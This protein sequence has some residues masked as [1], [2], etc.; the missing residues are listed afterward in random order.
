MNTFLQFPS[1]KEEP[2]HEIYIDRQI[3]DPIRELQRR[4]NT[5]DF[6]R[7]RPGEEINLEFPPFCSCSWPDWSFEDLFDHEKDMH[8]N[9]N[10]KEKESENNTKKKNKNKTKTKSKTQP[11]AIMKE[12]DWDWAWEKS[13]GEKSLFAPISDQVF[14]KGCRNLWDLMPS[15][16]RATCVHA[17]RQLWLRIENK[18]GL[19]VFDYDDC[20][21]FTT[22]CACGGSRSTTTFPIPPSMHLLERVRDR[23]GF[24]KGSRLQ[25]VCVTSRP[26]KY[27][28][29]MLKDAY[30]FHQRGA[31]HPLP[32][33]ICMHPYDSV[34]DVE[35]REQNDV[36]F[37]LFT[38]IALQRLLERPVVGSIGDS[39]HDVYGASETS[40]LLPNLHNW[41]WGIVPTWKGR[42]HT[43]TLESS[44]ELED[45]DHRLTG[46]HSLQVPMFA[47]PK[48]EARKFHSLSPSSHDLKVLSVAYT[49]DSDAT[50]LEVGKWCMDLDITSSPWSAD[51]LPTAFVNNIMELEKQCRV[52]KTLFLYS[53]N[54]KRTFASPC[55]LSPNNSRSDSM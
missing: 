55:A 19:V 45:W 52:K 36:P 17:C 8:P 5:Q 13:Q 32:L 50:M 41:R 38:R 14:P 21:V 54:P 3:P 18:N 2:V 7:L 6:S 25:A 11:I 12:W 31:D 35:G 29:Y 23:E 16:Y 27:I 42:T 33:T 53:M 39:L 47:V 46:L 44:V 4:S 40:A 43:K 26:A 22:C 28:N 20:L 15:V 1:P 51:H 34:L 37:K 24:S 30:L 48:E 49:F 9:E 10:E